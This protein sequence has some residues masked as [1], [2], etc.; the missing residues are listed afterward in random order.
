[1]IFLSQLPTTELTVLDLEHIESIGGWDF[2]NSVTPLIL[3]SSRDYMRRAIF[4]H[5][6]NDY[7]VMNNSLQKLLGVANIIGAT[8]LIRAI[9]QVQVLVD[10][11]LRMD[12]EMETLVDRYNE[13]E[14]LLSSDNLEKV[15]TGGHAC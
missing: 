15:L 9:L 10:K 11:Q 12:E 13:I 6:E 7:Q 14:E 4:A 1:M 3:K 8:R 5:E 2:L